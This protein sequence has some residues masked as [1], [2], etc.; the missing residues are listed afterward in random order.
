M[1]P[2]PVRTNGRLP[3]MIN[4][5]TYAYIHTNI[6]IHREISVDKISKL[7]KYIL[8]GEKIKTLHKQS[9]TINFLFAWKF[10]AYLIR[11]LK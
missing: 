4:V 2:K 5:Y 11:F 1:K 8:K 6:S 9:I 3:R 7:F 10:C